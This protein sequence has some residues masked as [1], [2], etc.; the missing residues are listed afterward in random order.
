MANIGILAPSSIIP[1]VELKIGVDLLEAHGHTV[2]VHEQCSLEDFAFA[3]SAKERADAFM[4]FALDPMIDVLWCGR[5]GYGASSILPLLSFQKLQRV[6][7]III[8]FSD[9]TSLL[10]VA[11][12]Q[13]GWRAI[14]GPMPS[15]RKF[16]ILPEADLESLYDALDLEKP[17]K[18]AKFRPRWISKKPKK[19]IKGPMFGGNLAV[20]ASIA[21]TPYQPSYPKGSVLFLED[22]GEPPARILRMLEQ[23]MQSG[24]CSRLSAILLGDFTDCKDGTPMVL[25]SLSKQSDP[26]I[27][28]APP[29]DL[30]K[31]LRRV[32]PEKKA[33]QVVL[34]QFSQSSGI[35]MVMGY[36][37]G[38]GDHC[39]PFEFG[40][41]VELPI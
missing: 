11:N 14:H 2:D 20:L 15:Q 32:L 40:I 18:P 34:E 9:I 1:K 30:L 35:P 7:K 25:R 3:G 22:I 26:E 5:G 41:H 21:G 36:P 28:K 27:L 37:A 10:H 17:I 24:I 8:G 39:S 29:Q 38:H 12:L 31:P 19:K 4:Q 6:K 13:W 33:L 23:L 16:S